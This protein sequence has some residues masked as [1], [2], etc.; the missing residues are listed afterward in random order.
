MAKTPTTAPATAVRNPPV[1][2]RLETNNILT[3][4]A[5]LVARESGIDQSVTEKFPGSTAEYGEAV[6]GRKI[7]PEQGGGYQKGTGKMTTAEDFDQ[8]AAGEG[9]EDVARERAVNYGGEDDV[10]DKLRGVKAEKNES[11]VDR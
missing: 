9:P 1:H 8:G 4:I 3:R 2:Q 11:R 10:N 6:G 5:S 7:P